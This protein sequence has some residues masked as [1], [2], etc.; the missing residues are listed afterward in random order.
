MYLFKDRIGGVWATC[1][2]CKF[3]GD[4]IEM[5][6][7]AREI[8]NVP[9]AVV[10]M[11]GEKLFTRDVTER[12]ASNYEHKVLGFNLKI[13]EFWGT[14]HKRVS[15]SSMH[16]SA[17]AILQHHG[18]YSGMEAWER[19]I[20]RFVGGTSKR[21]VRDLVNS[22]IF[23]SGQVE[24]AMGT[25]LVIPSFD[26][27]GRIRGLNFVTK[28]S[29]VFKELNIRPGGAPE[30]RDAGLA[31]IDTVTPGTSVA[32]AMNSLPTALQMQDAH[33]TTSTT[34]LPLVYYNVDTNNT[35]D[36]LLVPELVFWIQSFED[37]SVFKHAMR[38]QGSR[39]A[40]RPAT[41]PGFKHNSLDLYSVDPQN[42]HATLE[43]VYERSK[44]WP[45]VLNEFLMSNPMKA[46]SIVEQLGIEPI[47]RDMMYDACSR[48]QRS[49][50]KG[51]LEGSNIS[52]TAVLDNAKVVEER[53]NG[54]YEQ[55]VRN[56][57]TKC[58]L[59]A[60]IRVEEKRRY[61]IED[62]NVICGTINMNGQTIPFKADEKDIKK[63]GEFEWFHDRILD[64]G[65]GILKTTRA[66]RTKILEIAQEFYT[67]K[68]YVMT[69]RVGWSDVHGGFDFPQFQLTG[70]G[71]KPVC[72]TPD[73]LPLHAV[74]ETDECINLFKEF[75]NATD[76][77]AFLVAVFVLI[78]RNILADKLGWRHI[79]IV[80]GS[81]TELFTHIF[82]DVVAEY[83]L[84]AHGMLVDSDAK[85][86]EAKMAEHSTPLALNLGNSLIAFR[87]WFSMDRGFNVM[88]KLP[89]CAVRC[90]HTL[91]TTAVIMPKLG[92]DK[93]RVK[94]TA[95][96]L[97]PFLNWFITNGSKPAAGPSPI[98]I[99][100]NTIHAWMMS[101]YTLD[102]SMANLLQRA[103][104]MI[105]TGDSHK[106][107]AVS[108]RFLDATIAAYDAGRLT[109][110]RA[111][112]QA[113]FEQGET[114]K[115]VPE[116]VYRRMQA[117]GI[118]MVSA[119]AVLRCDK[120]DALSHS[121]SYIVFSKKVWDQRREAIKHQ[122]NLDS[123]DAIPQSDLT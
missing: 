75:K 68:T 123:L 13:K 21:E 100:I 93:I 84:V 102:K 88:L 37:L 116:K 117:S 74:K 66:H 63:K 71:P 44:P 77:D 115:V 5:F 25:T 65:G 87:K 101:V 73:P 55:A 14:A 90:V 1:R 121:A 99:T 111:Q 31:M 7:K 60:R 28:K 22:H 83:A 97:Y 34:P 107:P 49:R 118:P 20:S 6:M 122:T 56:G 29:Y 45:V 89:E 96:F 46:Y 33:F 41:L 70:D 114:Y 120:P 113:V 42:P 95:R 38:M 4:I 91:D 94:E 50:L 81:D 98:Q 30:Y 32:F 53:D 51:I 36:N 80:F 35:W 64:A 15:S 11:T 12:M 104:C 17:R 18:L 72:P 3:S 110:D 40:M 108:T 76:S 85:R 79:S 119:D 9:D 39:I 69:E 106:A 86:I 57:Q 8:D 109:T 58:V 112:D 52:N 2:T 82:N 59:N 62:K 43:Q 26:M 103:S 27:P 10:A 23:S 19:G 92:G 47:H 61:P 54:Y 24:G 105:L 48:A 78:V 16:P 67:P